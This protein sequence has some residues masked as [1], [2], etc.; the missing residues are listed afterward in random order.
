MI[1][2]VIPFSTDRDTFHEWFQELVHEQIPDAVLN[3]HPYSRNRRR[4]EVQRND[5][6]LCEVDVFPLSKKRIQIS[7]ALVH[8]DAIQLCTTF[9]KRATQEYGTPP[10]NLSV[11]TL[12]LNMQR[13]ALNFDREPTD[14]ELAHNSPEVAKQWL[15]KRHEETQ[16]ARKRLPPIDVI[17]TA[18]KR[19]AE[20]RGR[21]RANVYDEAH[22]EMTLRKLT[23]REAFEEVKARYPRET[24]STTF[25]QFKA[26]MTYRNRPAYQKGR[27]RKPKG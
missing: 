8:S 21:P 5:E 14:L 17:E 23:M 3:M 15:A 1:L 22:A 12:Q 20:Q 6:L 18:P 19:A 27:K 16:R 10:V 2:S 9:Y 7:A 25:E 24:S 13:A 4:Y 26:A 11:P